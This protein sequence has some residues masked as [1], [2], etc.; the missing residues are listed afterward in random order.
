MRVRN[1]FPGSWYVS[2][3][4][5]S[6]L[7][8]CPPEI[9]KV[10]LQEKL[11]PPQHVLLPDL[12]V[13]QGESQ[14]AVEFPLYHHLFWNGARPGAEPM[15]LIGGAR[16][17]QAA[18]ALLNLTLFGPSEA[19]MED[20]GLS[21]EKALAL[22]RETRWFQMK[23]V[24]GK[25]VPFESLITQTVLEEEPV[26]LGWVR[27]RRVRTNVFR[28]SP[29]E[30]EAVEVDLTP[31][32]PQL[33]PYPVPFD[34]VPTTLVKLGVEVLGGATGFTPTQPSCGLALCFNGQYL[35]IDAIPYLN[36]HLRAR[37]ISRNQVQALFL[38]HI[39]DD[40]CN[41]ISFLLY[42]RRIRVLT[43]PLIYRM[44]LRKLSLT[45][46][47]SEE[48]LQDY[49][50]FIP[51]TPGVESNF[52]GLRITAHYSSHSIPTIGARFETMHDGVDYRIFFS[53]DTQSLADLRRMQKAGV[54]NQDRF[55]EIAAPY[56][57]PA[58]LLIADGGE[59]SIHGDPA[60]ALESPAERIVFMHMDRLSDTFDAHFTSAS[61]GK[62]FVLL[63]GETDYNLT[64]TIEFLLEYFPEMPP[65]WISN[66]L[67]NQR[68]MKYNS[69]DVIIR[70][71]VHSDG[72]VYMLLT[73]H[74]SVVHHDG[75]QKAHLAQMEA[76][77]IIGEM[78]II[79]G[80]GIRNASVVAV[81]PVIAT[82]FS[83]VAFREYVYH[84]NLEG[85]LKR[86]WQNREL[87]QSLPYLR[88]LQQPIIRE[89]ARQVTLEHLPAR[90]APRPLKSI[91]DPFSLILPLGVDLKLSR[92]GEEVTIPAHSAPV[93]CS[94]G[95]SLVSEAEFQY[96]QLSAKQAADLRT[97]IPAFRFLW[98]E[99]LHL[100]LP[101]R[102]RARESA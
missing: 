8:G 66:L 11:P 24:H 18:A 47:R 72:R 81:S 33:P 42:N 5:H 97:R 53:G 77:E 65:M 71:G 61:A 58:Q 39:H 83:E 22:A 78:S 12:P 89:I 60:D 4:T 56:R 20:W 54:I 79:M 75:R 76:G 99:V 10:L 91:G 93:L 85:R 69:G 35:L 28:F 14:V 64:R 88:S 7:A 59:G 45:L 30:G 49:F 96:L 16:R 25:P 6:L 1:L 3:G 44:M 48:S 87:L 52:F 19:E 84:Q 50:Q 41:L 26:D 40:H 32:S 23:D 70:E 101:H 63:P 92:D 27:I 21:E 29:P 73:G 57:Q 86:L 80:Q 9:V 51:L 15:Q 36:H 74:A 67:A 37:G 102:V 17:V 55:L 2:D 34:L 46:D 90:T 13:S 100:P 43:T 95:V 98:E 38:S 31:E 82:A 94:S 62:R 68:V